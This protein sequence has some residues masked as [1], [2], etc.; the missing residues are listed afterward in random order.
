MKTMSWKLTPA[1]ETQPY[2]SK[3]ENVMFCSNCGKEIDDKAYLCVHCGVKVNK[4]QSLSD[5][6]NILCL[7]SFLFPLIGAV[8]YYIWVKSEPELAKKINKWS[9]IGFGVCLIVCLYF[10]GI[11]SLLFNLD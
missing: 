4:K 10:L 2:I 3:K 11:F 7:V 6:S 5:N 9:F 8:M 1:Y